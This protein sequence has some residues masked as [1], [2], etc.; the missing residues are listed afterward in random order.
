MPRTRIYATDLNGDV[1]K[2]AQE[3]PYPLPSMRNFTQN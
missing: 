1:L 2:S 3:G